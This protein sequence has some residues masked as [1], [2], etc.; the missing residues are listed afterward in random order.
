MSLAFSPNGKMLASGSCSRGP[1]K[2]GTLVLYDSLSGRELRRIAVDSNDYYTQVSFSA[3]GKMLGSA[4]FGVQFWDSAT[5]RQLYHDKEA[6]RFAFAPDDRTLVVRN[7][8]NTIRLL[9]IPSGKELHRFSMPEEPVYWPFALSSDGRT[10]AWATKDRAIECWELASWKRRRR[11]TGHQGEIFSLVFSVDGRTLFSSSADTTI[12]IWDRAR[13]DEVRK[14]RWNENDLPNLWRDLAEENAERADHAIW[15]L[16]AVPERSMPFL[17]KHIYPIATVNLERLNHLITD[18]DSDQFA[19]RDK[20]MHELDE[21]GELTEAAL[22]KMLDGKPSREARRRAQQLLEKLRGPLP[23]GERLRSLRAVEVLEHAGTEQARRLLTRL[24]DGAPEA[25]LT[26][27]AKVALQRLDQRAH[28]R[29][30]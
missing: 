30:K 17:E 21:L 3:D 20:A 28:G 22:R 19:V 18:L 27:E 2:E 15:L 4:G 11:L 10:L 29:D 6:S 24:V 26:R 7:K 8:D 9:D 16:A 1:T 5:G 12:L 25:R 13:T 14:V 23:A